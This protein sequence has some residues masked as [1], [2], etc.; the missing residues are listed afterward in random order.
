ML[1]DLLDVFLDIAVDACG[2]EVCG[3]KE[4]S[5]FRS[6]WLR[7]RLVIALADNAVAIAAVCRRDVNAAAFAAFVCGGSCDSALPRCPSIRFCLSLC[8]FISN[9]YAS[10]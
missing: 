10:G 3:H 5:V 4:P 2:V 6:G 7:R 1:D 8:R 9:L